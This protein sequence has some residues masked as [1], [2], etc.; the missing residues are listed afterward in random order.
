MGY[1]D[2]VPVTGLGRILAA[3]TALCGIGIIAL[4]TGVLAGA[5]ADAIREARSA[6]AP[7][8]EGGRDRISSG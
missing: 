4:P 3:M 5:F 7:E 1:G 6:A 8:G 2:A